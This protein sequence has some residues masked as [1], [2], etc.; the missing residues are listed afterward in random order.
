MTDVFKF[1]EDQWTEL[2]IVSG[3]QAAKTQKL[4]L[5][6]RYTLLLNIIILIN[7]EYSL[8]NQPQR[9]RSCGIIQVIIPHF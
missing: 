9:Y 5:V 7:H 6:P 2:H 8:S 1:T 4:N 3:I